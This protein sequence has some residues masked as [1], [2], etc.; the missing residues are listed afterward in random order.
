MSVIFVGRTSF[1]SGVGSLL[2][3]SLVRRHGFLS[4]PF[5][6]LPVLV[7]PI[8]PTVKDLN[9]EPTPKPRLEYRFGNIYDRQVATVERYRPQ[10]RAPSPPWPE[11]AFVRLWIQWRPWLVG[12]GYLQDVNLLFRYGPAH[13]L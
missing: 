7:R 13:D 11:P 3:Q 2:K 12:V 9:R 8:W 6:I 5:H 1:F 4:I 10:T